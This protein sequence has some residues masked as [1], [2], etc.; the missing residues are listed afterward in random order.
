MSGRKKENKQPGYYSGTCL[1]FTF[2]ATFVITAGLTFGIIFGVNQLFFIPKQ[3]PDTSTDYNPEPEPEPEPEPTVREIDFQPVV[4]AWVNSVG[5][6]KSILIYDLDL[7]KT[8]AAY[9][10]DETYNTAS[11]YKLF[12]VYEGYKRVGTG[13]WD[14][15]AKAGATGYTISKCLDLAIRE[16][17]SSCAETLWGMIGRDNLNIIIENEWGITHSDISKLTSNVGDIALIIKRFYEHPDFDNPELLNKIWDSFLNQPPTTYD[18]RQGLP[19]GFTKASVYNKVGWDYNPDGRYWN[20]Y[21]DAAIVK[22]PMDDGA[23]RNFIVV[24]MSNKVDF[25]YIRNLGTNLEEKFYET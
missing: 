21:H 14:A 25:K 9:N 24:V 19:S 18:W 4:D 15:N 3:A 6:N 1:F 16:S 7:G 11:L 2:L 17:H 12:V 22:F 10:V 20:I 8:V 23:T 5:G 13:E